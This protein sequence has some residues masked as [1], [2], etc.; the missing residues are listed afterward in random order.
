MVSTVAAPAPPGS[1][2][3]DFGRI[4]ARNGLGP[5]NLVSTSVLPP[6]IAVPTVTASPSTDNA[7][8]LVTAVRSSFTDRRAS[9]SRPSYVCANSTRSGEFASTS[10]ASAAAPA[11]PLNT[12]SGSS[13]YT[14]AAPYSPSAGAIVSASGPMYTASTVSAIS[15]AFVSSS[16]VL[17]AGLSPSASANTQTFASAIVVAFL[18][19]CAS[20]D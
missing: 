18:P 3:N 15:R 14:F 11:T 16:S 13:A 8:P 12:P 6:K 2:A 17:V 1:A 9:A 20:N 19:T 5:E 10:G 4:A 7:V